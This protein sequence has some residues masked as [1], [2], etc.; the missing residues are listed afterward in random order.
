MLGLSESLLLLDLSLLPFEV[1]AESSAEP[2]FVEVEVLL[3]VAAL[4][5]A[6]FFAAGLEEV[7]EE[8]LLEVEEAV[9]LGLALLLTEAAGE[10]VD[11]ELAVPIGVGEAFTVAEGEALALGFGDAIGVALAAGVVDAEGAEAGLAAELTVVEDCVLTPALPPLL[12]PT[13]TPTPG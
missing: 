1:E 3:S 10:A 5:L 9:A 12:R 2:D 4:S 7:F 8:L 13:L 11:L 6:D